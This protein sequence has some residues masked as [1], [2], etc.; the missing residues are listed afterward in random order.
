MSSQ[1]VGK[2]LRANHEDNSLVL[3]AIARRFEEL[4]N[5]CPASVSPR[6]RILS[7]KRGDFLFI[8]IRTSFRVAIDNE[9]P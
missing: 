6:Q 4:L 3:P 2:E 9:A 8:E 5:D 7:E 1:N